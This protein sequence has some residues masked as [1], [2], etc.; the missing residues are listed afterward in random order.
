[1]NIADE[2]FA[3]KR[4]NDKMKSTVEGKISSLMEVV[5]EEIQKQ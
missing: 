3:I 1:M 2:Y 4:D 5:E